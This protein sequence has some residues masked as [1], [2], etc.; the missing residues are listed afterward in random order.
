VPTLKINTLKWTTGK[1]IHPSTSRYTICSF[2]LE[3]SQPQFCLYFSFSPCKSPSPS[4]YFITLRSKFSAEHW[5]LRQAQTVVRAEVLFF[6]YSK[7]QHDAYFIIIFRSWLCSS[8]M[9]RDYTEIVTSYMYMGRLWI[10]VL[11]AQVYWNLTCNDQIVRNNVL[12]YE[13]EKVPP[14]PKHHAIEMYWWSGSRTSHTVEPSII[15]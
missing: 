5:I 2:Y 1:C 14:V 8:I 15:S 12:F 9:F 11:H 7:S 4:S 3:V 6:I 13:M 10:S